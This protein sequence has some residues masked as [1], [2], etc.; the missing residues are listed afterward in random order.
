MR[1]AVLF[2][3]LLPTFISAQ[4]AGPDALLRR[5]IDSQQHGDY[6]AAIAGYRKVIELR[7]NDVEARVNL[8]AALSHEGKFDEAI[9]MYRSALPSLKNK[10]A[11]LLNLALAYYKEGDF[12]HARE[13]FAVLHDAQPNDV[14]PIIL[15]GDSDLHLDK[16]D[17]AISLLGPLESRFTSNMDFEYV[18]GRALITSGRRRE[19]IERIEKVAQAGPSSDAYLFAGATLLDLNEYERARRDLEQALRLAPTMPGVYTQVGIA[20]DKTG[21]TANAEAAFREALK[22]NPND[23]QANLY[24]GA[25]LYKRR[26]TAEAKK[27]LDQA[28]LLK[29]KD[30]MAR[31]ESAMLKSTSGDYETAAHELEQLAKDDPDWLEPHVELAALYYRLHRPEDGAKQRQIVEQIT[32]KQQAQ[33][34]GK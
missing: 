4:D 8:G 12:E 6:T 9:E 5:A 21:D 10:N 34:P 26:E 1:F 31:Y 17:D 28:I 18:L 33:G 19:G 20:R 32:A 22:S 30:S 13:Q 15:L 23:F 24:L 2:I 27:Y 16:A 29:P 14:R 11:V 3:A 25:I 7:P